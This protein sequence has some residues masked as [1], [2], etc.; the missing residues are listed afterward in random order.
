MET[1]KDSGERTQFGTGAVRD[2]HAGKGRYD[3]LPMCVIDRLA[4]HYEAGALKYS[5]R[6]WEKGIPAHSFADS[7]MRHFTKY[8]DGQNDEDHLI[9]AIWNLCGLAWTEMKK[10][11]MMD[12]PARME[13]EEEKSESKQIADLGAELA[14]GWAKAI[15]QFQKDVCMCTVSPNVSREALLHKLANFDDSEGIK[16]KYVKQMIKRTETDADDG[17]PIQR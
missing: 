8:M 12:I 3:L 15:E 5:D 6:N 17:E 11:E 14:K 2:M 9:A 16:V 13:L 7:A 4:K 1:I 10:P